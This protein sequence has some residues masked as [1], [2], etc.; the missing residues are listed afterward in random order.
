MIATIASVILPGIYLVRDQAG[1]QTRARSPELY[2]R[3][4]RVTVIDGQIVGAASATQPTKTYE[5]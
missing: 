2:R 3:G 5:V 4:E 1:K